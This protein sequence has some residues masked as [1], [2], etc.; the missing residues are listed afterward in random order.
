MPKAKKSD[1]ALEASMIAAIKRSNDWASGK[2][3]PLRCDGAGDKVMM[4]CATV[5]K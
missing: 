5:N 2:F 3:Q 1:P 4:D